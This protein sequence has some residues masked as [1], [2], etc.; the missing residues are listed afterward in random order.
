MT[1]LHT[2]QDEVLPMRVIPE[3]SL[4]K[5]GGGRTWGEALIQDYGV[6]PN[7]L[8][9]MEWVSFETVD[10]WEIYNGDKPQYTI[11]IKTNVGDQNLK[12]YLGF[13]VNHSDDGISSSSDH[14]KIKFS[15]E[16]FEVYG[17]VGQTIDFANEHFNKVQPLASLQDD[18]VTF[19]FNGGVYA[20][21]LTLENEVYFAAQ[22][23]DAN[24]VLLADISEK[25]S[26]TLMVKESQYNEV[27][28]LTFWPAQFF[29][30]AEGET[31]SYIKYVFTNSDGSIL[32]TQSDDDEVVENTPNDGLNR[33][34]VFEF[35]CY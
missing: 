13:F 23:Y 4:P 8:N 15:D 9:D 14:K 34:F 27:R 22:A 28:N 12:A 10:K 24:D 33:S 29:N 17:G 31:I 19:S 20:N 35:L 11:T 21:D 2:D 1:T 30:I 3:S 6:G 18:F 16:F 26:K 5:N 25:T 32:I 7:V